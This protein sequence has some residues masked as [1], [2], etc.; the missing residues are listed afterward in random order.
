ME[1]VKAGPDTAVGFPRRE[2]ELQAAESAR[3]RVPSPGALADSP[4][5]AGKPPRIAAEVEPRGGV[6]PGWWTRSTVWEESRA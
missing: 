4:V 2:G 5:V 6:V 1:H 3:S